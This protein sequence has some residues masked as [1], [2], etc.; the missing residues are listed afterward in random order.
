MLGG[1]QLGRMLI[2]EATKF[3]LD[4]WFMDKDFDYPVPSM[5]PNFVKGDFKNYEDVLAFGKAVDIVTIE[6]E[7]VNTDALKVLENL[8]KKVYPQARVIETIKDKGLQKMFYQEESLPTSEFFLVKD[9]AEIEAKISSGQLLFPFVQKSRLAGYDGKGVV[10]V[11]SR[12]DLPKL[13]DT[14]SVI[15]QLVDIEKELAVIISRNTNG[16]TECFPITEMVFEPKGN[17]LDYLLCPAEVSAELVT[18]CNSLA[19]SIITKLEMVGILAVEFF[20]DKNGQIL[21][22]EVAPRPHNSG[23]HTIDTGTYSQYNSHLRCLLDWPLLPV[24]QHGYAMMINVLGSEGHVGSPVYNGLNSIMQIESV[25]PHIY[26]KK[27]TKPLRKMGHV[28]IVGD[29]KTELLEKMAQIKSSLK[30]ESCQK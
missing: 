3:D 8:G 7:N 26:G 25:Y 15:E 5:F 28:T 23:H 14:P 12:Q 22:N 29:S 18:N 6:I 19:T 24:S 13:L 30:V 10:T 20:L 2:Q 21:I 9:K 4:M 27:L 11:K 16:D 17:L 1:G